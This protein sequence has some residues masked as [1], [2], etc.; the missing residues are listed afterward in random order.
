MVHVGSEGNVWTQSVVVKEYFVE[1]VLWTSLW[2][3]KKW[4][5]L[6]YFQK[7]YSLC[8]K[9]ICLSICPSTH[10]S[11]HLPFHP[12]IYPSI[13]PSISQSS[14][15]LYIHSSTYPST[16]HLFINYSSIHSSITYLS[17]PTI[18]LSITFPS[19]SIHPSRQPSIYPSCGDLTLLPKR[20]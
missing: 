9:S 14:H 13:H 7:A 1:T 19:Y 12:S 8:E 3:I 15:L 17:I 18:Q 20:N 10:P 16:C 6:T 2:V 11:I 5:A 4:D